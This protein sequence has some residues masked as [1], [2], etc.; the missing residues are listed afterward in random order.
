MSQYSG[1]KKRVPDNSKCGRKILKAKY[2]RT[3]HFTAFDIRPIRL[4]EK[5]AG[6]LRRGTLQGA[7]RKEIT[8]MLMRIA[9]T[10]DCCKIELESVG[11]ARPASTSVE[12]TG[13]NGHQ[14][15]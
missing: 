1:K 9:E 14:H 8:T 15:A 5:Q 7:S 6:V 13:S 10:F 11:G 12:I 2:D 3:T 4:D